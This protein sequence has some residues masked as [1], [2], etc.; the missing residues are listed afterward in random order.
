[1]ELI[2]DP[3]CSVVFEAEPE[4]KNIMQRPSRDLK[5]KLFGR[6][7]MVASLL[8]GMSVLIV[9]IAVFLLALYLGKG[10]TQAR[11][12][13]FATLVIANI[14]LIAANLSW[15]QDIIKTIKENRALWLVAGGALLSLSI[16]LYVPFLRD[17][18]HFSIL[19]PDDILIAGI[20]GILSVIWFKQRKIRDFFKNENNKKPQ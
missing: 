20:A 12:L 10:E 19:H 8:Q 6:K 11:T 3:A 17:L 5:D 9:V 2:I 16:V 14:A 4:E 1:L 15:E 7:S 18:F 13:T